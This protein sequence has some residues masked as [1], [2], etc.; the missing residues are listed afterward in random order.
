MRGARAPVGT[1][2]NVP[3]TVRD[4]RSDELDAIARVME[5]AYEEYMP[6]PDADVSPEY[7]KAFDGYRQDITDV[8]SRFG[9]TQLIVAEDGGNIAG[10]VTFYPPNARAEYPTEAE[11]QDWPAEWA[12]FRLLAVD[13]SARG[14]GIGRLLTE[15]CLRRAQA[16]GAP[17]VGL[18]TTML[19]NVAR[20]MYK[21]M[22]WARAP[23][24]D[25]YPIP[26]FVVEAYTLSL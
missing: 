11:H 21:R 4:A 18:H 7:R 24:Y 13:P 8:R 2:D 6:P 3:I 19:M 14:K 26:D 20:E 9:T 16:L 22:G 5:A 17:V 25:F 15:E 10:A 1:L 12:A 23:E